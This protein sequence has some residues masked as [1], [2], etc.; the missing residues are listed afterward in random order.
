MIQHQ[1]T[2]R[3]GGSAP[4]DSAFAGAEFFLPNVQVLQDEIAEERAEAE[5]TKKAAKAKQNGTASVAQGNGSGTQDGPTSSGDDDPRV[6]GAAPRSAKPWLHEAYV[7]KSKR[8]QKQL[9]EKL[10]D[11]ME[12]TVKIALDVLRD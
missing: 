7:N 10:A 5:A 8:T 9:Q 6:D 4:H 1:P 11:T 3:D 12:R 2:A